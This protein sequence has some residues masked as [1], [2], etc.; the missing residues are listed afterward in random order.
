[1]KSE[2]TA[3]RPTRREPPVI[4]VIGCGAITEALHLPALA[5]HPE[6]M[7]RVICV[8]PNA[9]RA[10]EMTT[11]FGAAA[12][13]VRYQDVVADIDAAIVAVPPRLHYPVATDLLGANVDVLCEKPLAESGEQARALVAKARQA[14]RSLCVNN[15]R[16]L[17][18]SSIKVRDLVASGELGTVRR[19]EYSWGEQFDWPTASGAYFGVAA[20]GRGVLADKGSHILDLVC[21]WLG[22]KPEVVSYEDDSMG[23]TEAVAVL[24]FRM[25]ACEGTVRFSWLSRYENT[26]EV[27]GDRASVSGGLFDWNTLNFKPGNGRRKKL[28]LPSSAKIP[29][30]L[31]NNMLDNFVDVVRGRAEP[32]VSGADVL[33]SIELLDD[34]YSRRKRLPAPWYD[35]WHRVAS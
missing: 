29:Q 11:K 5:R 35:A 34:C 24:R 18:P 8:D 2:P 19:L 26:F 23:G 22:G 13:A 16:R 31:G 4:A 6:I 25:G 20:G 17:Y 9:D 33:P 21:W 14:H 1:V 15:Y 7:S 32:L 27:T 12:A 30:D 3:E 28:R 10:R